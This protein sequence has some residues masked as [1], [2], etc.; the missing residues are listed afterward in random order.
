MRSC[1]PWAAAA[2][3]AP[4]AARRLLLL[5]RRGQTAEPVPAAVSAEVPPLEQL[6]RYAQERWEVRPRPAA[7]RPLTAAWARRCVMPQPAAPACPPT[8]SAQ[9]AAGR[10]AAAPTLPA[11]LLR[12]FPSPQAMQMFLL[13]GQD[14]C[15]PK[16]PN[17]LRMAPLDLRGLLAAA[18]L[19]VKMCAAAWPSSCTLPLV[20]SS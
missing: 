4:T 19:T 17:W 14:S 2:P 13:T 20:L 8:A 18:G 11:P 16:M 5:R 12:T 6:D 15:G 7:S 3:G 10:R 1:V 9:V